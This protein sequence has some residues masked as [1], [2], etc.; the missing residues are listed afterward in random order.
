MAIFF[1]R[2]TRKIITAFGDAFNNI[3]INR[4]TKTGFV[5]YR[6]PIRMGDR[7]K[8]F[9]FLNKNRD[10]DI[11]L[12]LVGFHV[13]SIDFDE[14]R[15]MNPT[16]KFFSDD[17]AEYIFAPVPYNYTIIFSIYT[18]NMNDLYD[19]FETIAAQY[20]KTRHYPLIE[21][22]FT[23]GSKIT[24]D[25]PITLNSTIKNTPEELTMNDNKIL[26]FDLNFIVKGWIYNT[27]RG[28]N[29]NI[30]S[31]DNNAKGMEGGNGA[32][33]IEKIDLRFEEYVTEYYE[34]IS[35]YKD[36]GGDWN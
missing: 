18:M 26:K 20:R 34:T 29:S 36:T 6:V 12:P 8:V 23:D 7:G 22:Q 24:R 31:R 3:Y 19:I 32:V 21:F 15:T 14:E 9:A 35:L 5:D 25:L 2:M 27:I 11:Q 30:D 33:L 1:P 13:D 28:V 16:T 4:R 10:Y 17:N